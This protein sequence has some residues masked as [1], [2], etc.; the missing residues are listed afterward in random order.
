[1]ELMV[2]GINW[3]ISRYLAQVF[4]SSYSDV[5]VAQPKP[6]KPDLKMKKPLL[7]VGLLAFA[8]AAQAQFSVMVTEP[9]ALAGSLLHTTPASPPD[10]NAW[11]PNY[12]DMNNP[13][14][15]V[16]AFTVIGQDSLSC[17]ALTNAADVA[18]K[19]AIVYRGTCDFSSKVVNA[20]NAG[21]LAV[22]V[23]NNAGAPIA[24]GGGASADLVIIPVVMISQ[25]DGA[26][27][28]DEVVAG[29]VEMRIG[30]LQGFFPNNLSIM[31]KDVLNPPVAAFPKMLA[32]N[33]TFA[34]GSWV[35]NFGVNA[36]SDVTLNATVMHNG[37]AV[38]NETSTPVSINPTDSAYF[39]LPSFT[40][41]TYDGTYELM[42]TVAYGATDD[43]DSDNSFGTTI[44]FDSL[45][46]VSP[47][48]PANG[49][50]KQETFIRSGSSDYWQSCVRFSDPNAHL[51]RVTG[52]WAAAT[53]RAPGNM[54][55]EQIDAQLYEWNDPITNGTNASF[56]DLQEVMNG[57]YVYSDSL[58]DEV[59]V[60][61]ELFE[62]QPLE[63]DQAYLFCVSNSNPD[64]FIGFSSSLDYLHNFLISDEI[65]SI[66]FTDANAYILGFGTETTT[67]I[68]VAME[69]VTIGI[70]E[71]SVENLTP[72]PNP[73]TN[74]LTIPMK[75][76]NGKAMLTVFDGKGAQVM[77]KAITIA[78]DKLVL[79]VQ[80]LNSGI[81]NFQMNFENGKRASFRVVVN[82]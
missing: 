27:I 26:L 30:S 24:M 18:G 78:S 59:P 14:N 51:M 57:A 3:L 9:S 73:T 81:Y 4:Q 49:L 20:Q 62:P 74:N 79:D 31:A 67:A 22:V 47:I 8:V 66:L 15:A 61:I 41:A 42:Y 40:Q 23:V 36:Q 54:L 76:N 13:A 63:D 29:N 25:A 16:Q 10:V 71:N 69:D 12:P 34:V 2:D 53:Y 52:Y 50:P 17:A 38:Y 5:E 1:M 65:S 56:D 37:A 7:I 33:Y 48:D 35:S 28:H 19:I 70:K 68:A 82:K 72:Y 55:G 80:D 75:G 46:A 58:S 6:I 64:V 60:F 32:D 39:Q 43:Y 11:S 77:A 44:V 21:A 45:Y